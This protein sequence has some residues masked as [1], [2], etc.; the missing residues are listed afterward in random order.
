MRLPSLIL[1][2]CAM[3]MIW[4]C[5]APRDNPYDPQS[6]AY[7]GLKGSIQ[8]KVWNL[9]GSAYLS[10][11]IIAG[12]SNRTVASG[13]SGAYFIE[14]VTAGQ[15]TLIC[16][17]QGFGADTQTVTVEDQSA[18]QVDFHLDALPTINEFHATSHAYR[19]FPSS[20]YMLEAQAR[21]G[22]L[23]GRNDLDSVTLQIEDSRYSMNYDSTVGSVYYYSYELDTSPQGGFNAYRGKQLICTVIDAAGNRAVAYQDSIIHFFPELPNASYPSGTIVN[24]DTMSLVWDTYNIQFPFVYNVQI[25]RGILVVWSQ[26][27][28]PANVTTIDTIPTPQPNGY[29]Y[30]WTVEVMD[31]YDNSARS[32]NANFTINI[33]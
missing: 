21:L 29:D 19:I 7:I 4:G 18:A 14:N 27:N 5:D 10:N 32:Q 30:S 1:I 15:Y 12:I 25:K 6:P 3:L 20:Y 16:S 33:P 22:D 24:G 31:F 8:G 28:I 13:A 2:A 11:A 26:A 23:D 17:L 9:A